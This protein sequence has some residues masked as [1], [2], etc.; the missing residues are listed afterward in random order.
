[1]G[2]GVDLVAS[3]S[4][5]PPEVVVPASSSGLFSMKM[6]ASCPGLSDECS[7]LPVPPI[8]DILIAQSPCLPLIAQITKVGLVLAQSL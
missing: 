4:G 1:M 3:S 8:G 7:S 2:L 6:L 5:Y